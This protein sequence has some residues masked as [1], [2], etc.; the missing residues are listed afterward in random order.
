MAE[1][2]ESVRVDRQKRQLEQRE[3]IDWS[4]KNV[5]LPRGTSLPA[6]GIPGQIFALEKAGATK[7]KLMLFDGGLNNWITVGP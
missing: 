4:G 7:D 1:E 3:N 6:S 2:I 5:V